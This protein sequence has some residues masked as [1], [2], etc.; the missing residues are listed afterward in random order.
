MT[1]CVMDMKTCNKLQINYSEG[2][3]VEEIWK[4]IK[5]YEGLYQVSNLGRVKSLNYKHTG[6]SKIRKTSKDRY[7]YD[8][9]ILN[10]N[11]KS[12]SYK[13]HRLVAQ[14]FIP[15]HNNYPSINHKDENKSNNYVE[16]LEWCTVAYNNS[17]GSRVDM[18]SKK[19]ICMNTGEIFSGTREAQEKTGVD[20]GGISR[21]CRK[22]YKTSG[23][24]PITGEKLVWRYLDEVTETDESNIEGQVSLL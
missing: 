18:H 14:A 12:K 3:F 8:Q 10:K 19:V 17:Y 23:K 24:H 2:G 16:N 9:I 7:G 22:I 15:N 4:D 5:G 13:I 11:S 1:L 21:C 20:H 6:K